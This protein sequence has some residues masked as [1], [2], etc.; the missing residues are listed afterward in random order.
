MKKVLLIEDEKMLISLYREKFEME[1][2]EI[3]EAKDVVDGLK[4]AKKEKPNLVILDILLP[5]E[6]GLSFLKTQKNEVL[7]SKI[8]VVI[9]SNFDDLET[10]EKADELGAKEYLVKANYEPRELVEIIKKY[11]E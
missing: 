3:F 10:R 6:N 5:G 9:F 11:L 1:G 8:P 4:L 7:I 2:F